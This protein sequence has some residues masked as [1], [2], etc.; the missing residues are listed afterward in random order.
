MLSNDIAQQSMIQRLDQ[1]VALLMEER[2]FFKEKL[3]YAEMV[4]HLAQVFQGNL[5][6]AEF[7]TISES[8]LKQR[9]SG[10]MVTEAVAGTLNELA[11][12]KLAI[13]DEAIKRK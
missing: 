3:D 7:N 1:V 8:D 10:I 13:F 12:D 5:S 4:N 6:I 9:C 2:P 11:P